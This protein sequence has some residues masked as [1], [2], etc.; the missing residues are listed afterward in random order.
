MSKNQAEIGKIIHGDCIQVLKKAPARCID[1]VV[2]DPPYLVNYKDRDGRKIQGDRYGDWLNPA[3]KEIHRVLKDDRFCISFYG[4]NHAEKFLIA[5]KRAG[6]VPVGHLVFRKDYPSK[7]GF[8]GSRHECAYLLAKGNPEKPERVLRD[9]LPWQ[10]TG[11]KLH[12]TQKPIEAISPLIEAFSKPG[13]VVLDPFAGS[14][15]T[16]VAAA[17][18]GRRYLC[19][20]KDFKYF[21]TAQ[22]RLQKTTT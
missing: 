3:F 19:V 13:D 18:L 7:I 15:T 10:Y 14:A 6:F 2:T 22:W 21:R 9:V 16:A 1:L 17:K 12:P 20:E 11:N 4:W 5:W 8:L